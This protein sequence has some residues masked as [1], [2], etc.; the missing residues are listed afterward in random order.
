M[1]FEPGSLSARGL[2]F[3]GLSGSIPL[4]CW[5]SVIAVTVAMVWGQCIRL[6]VVH[7]GELGLAS[8]TRCGRDDFILGKYVGYTCVR[9]GGGWQECGGWRL[10]HEHSF[11]WEFYHWRWG[12]KKELITSEL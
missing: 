8:E 6:A 11:S 3:K 9:N 2:P 10:T 12:N 4:V 5:E 1:P 7:M